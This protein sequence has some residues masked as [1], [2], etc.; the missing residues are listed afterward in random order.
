MRILVRSVLGASA[1][2][3]AIALLKVAPHRA[4]HAVFSTQVPSRRAGEAKRNSESKATLA[5]SPAGK[6]AAL[7]SQATRDQIA[8][9]RDPAQR[10][11]LVD[12]AK[13]R[14]A[15]SRGAL[16]QMLRRLPLEKLDLLS[17]ILAA[18]ELDTRTAMLELHA[19]NPSPSGREVESILSAE[20]AARDANVRG[21]LDDDQYAQYMSYWESEPYS[22][23]IGQIA[24]VMR[25]QGSSVSPDL[26]QQML[27]TYASVE[28]LF[29]QVGPSSIETGNNLTS[30]LPSNDPDAFDQHL[31][32]AMSKILSPE[33]FKVFMDAQ[34][35][36][37]YVY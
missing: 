23:S 9:L 24:D 5:P 37:D 29:Q 14:I 22:Q 4:H 2:L 20:N 18:S 6:P 7:A 17:G 21:I 12:Q 34:N 27:I 35:K 33:D 32:D 31:A 26:Q 25:A 36:I 15:T 3:A 10:Q 13:I 8:R 19:A 1:I 30:P 16:F 11:R 28:K